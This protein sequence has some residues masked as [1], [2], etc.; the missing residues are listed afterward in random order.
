VAP[1]V[2]ATWSAT[3][4]TMRIRPPSGEP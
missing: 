1:G 3:V 4:P 2:W